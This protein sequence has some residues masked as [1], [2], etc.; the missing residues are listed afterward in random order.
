MKS[1]D[2]ATATSGQLSHRAL[3]VVAATFSWRRAVEV[4]GREVALVQ[5]PPQI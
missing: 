2:G 3:E 5:R 4:K 1:Q